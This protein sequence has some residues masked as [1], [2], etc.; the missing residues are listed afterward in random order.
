MLLTIWRHGEA[1]AAMTDRERA[2]TGGG[3]DDVSFGCHQFQQACEL[4]HLPQPDT[5]LHSPW[6]RTRQ[7]ARIISAVYTHADMEPSN[8]VQPGASVGDVDAAL[9]LLFEQE[10][11]NH[12]LLVSHQ[13][14]VSQLAD[15]YAGQRGLVPGLTPGGLVTLDLAAPGSACGQL[16]FWALPPEYEAGV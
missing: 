12:V 1:G 10:R 11:G 2:L 3:A 6:L 13:P 5:I 9:T 15:Y 14:L 4:R 7:T 16:L 8:A